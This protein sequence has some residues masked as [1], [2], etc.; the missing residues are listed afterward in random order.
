M[1]SGGCQNGRHTASSEAPFG[2][3]V[4]GWAQTSSYGYPAGAAV[5][6]VNDVE[7]PIPK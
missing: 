6:S 1:V 3:T 5:N 4:W 7:L 2:I